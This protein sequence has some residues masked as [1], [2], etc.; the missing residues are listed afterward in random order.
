MAR[1]KSTYDVDPGR[2]WVLF[3]GHD[4]RA[5][6]LPEPD[7]RH[8][9]DRQLDVLRRRHKYVFGEPQHLGLGARD[10]RCLQLI[11]S[12]GVFT[13]AEWA[14]WAGI[15]FAGLNMIVQVPGDRQPPVLSIMIFFVD[16]I[17][18]WGL[19]TYG[20]KDRYSLAG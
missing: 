7:L 18:I 5:R 3:A 2:G 11:T 19:F 8:R 1:A 17:I 16:V 14:R 12:Y 10:R 6:R 15:T 4:A 20:G 13:Y 9:D